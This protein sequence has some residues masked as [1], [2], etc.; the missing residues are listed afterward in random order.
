MAPLNSTFLVGGIA[1]ISMAGLAAHESAIEQGREFLP[2]AQKDWQIRSSESSVINREFSA[3]DFLG[4]IEIPSIKRIA[5]IFEGTS[6]AELSRGVGH[7]TQSVMPGV[8]DNSVISGHRDTVFS[9]LGK[10]KIG[11]RIVVTVESGRYIYQV[12]RIRIVSKDDRTVIVP[13]EEA[14]LTLSTC[15]PFVFIGNAPK[16]YIVVAS[17]EAAKLEKL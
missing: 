12:K 4:T 11:A 9:K 1:V 6:E 10:V 14:T 17:L 16:R 5:N 7:Y 13:T 3:G 15:Y 2:D 8:T